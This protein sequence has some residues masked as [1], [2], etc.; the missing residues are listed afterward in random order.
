M[1]LILV[2]TTGRSG[3]AFLS[4]AFGG[5]RFQKKKIH[6]AVGA[7]A[8][9]THEGWGGIPVS[10]LKGQNDLSSH[11][12]AKIV[13]KYLNNM[14]IKSKSEYPMA[15]KYLVTDH[16]VGRYC[17]PSIES[18]NIDYQVIRLFRDHKDVASSFLRRVRKRRSEYTKAEFLKFY[19]EIWSHSFYQPNDEFV[20]NKISNDIWDNISMYD[21][22]LWYSKEVDAQWSE[23]KKIL[24]RNKYL[25][26]T[27][28]EIIK[29]VGLNKVMR[30]IE[31]PW[32]KKWAEIRANG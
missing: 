6:Q 9:V 20:I 2:F 32:S 1:K 14:I 21:K 16:R 25:E 5:A 22:F 19:N 10:K 13:D 17:I 4:Q 11:S 28:D 15:E 8:L 23:V 26:V 30:F 29:P 24:P 3:T 31:I 18:T 12:S 7:D 27:F